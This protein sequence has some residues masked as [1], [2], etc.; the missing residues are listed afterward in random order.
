MYSPTHEIKCPT[1]KNY[2]AVVLVLLTGLGVHHLEFEYKDCMHQR[3]TSVF[4]VKI[5][6]K[7]VAQYIYRSF[8][9]Q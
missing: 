3:K 6:Q 9:C 7:A 1:N 4:K 2:S 8:L 5:F